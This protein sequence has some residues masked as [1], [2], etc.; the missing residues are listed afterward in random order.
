MKNRWPAL[1]ILV[2]ISLQVFPQK[3]E[4]GAANCVL[5][6]L[7]VLDAAEKPLARYE[8]NELAGMIAR[9]VAPTD[10]ENRIHRISQDF[11]ESSRILRNPVNPVCFPRSLHVALRRPERMKIAAS[12]AQAGRG[13][14]AFSAH[15]MPK[16]RN[17][18]RLRY[19]F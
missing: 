5:T 18:G 7:E 4:P 17:L 1:L 15:P 8:G 2:A 14:A 3:P 9:P 6:R 10:V 13:C 11:F 19:F 12:V 16:P